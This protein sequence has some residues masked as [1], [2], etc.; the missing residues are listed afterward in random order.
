MNRL[1]CNRLTVPE[2]TAKQS[3]WFFTLAPEII[4]FVLEPT[5]KA[6]VLCPN[7]PVSPAELSMVTSVIVRP[8]APLIEKV[9]TGVLTILSP[10]IEDAPSNYEHRR[11]LAW[12]FLHCCQIHPTKGVHCRSRSGPMHR[13][14]LYLFLILRKEDRTTLRMPM[15]SRLGIWPDMNVR[16][17]QLLEF[18]C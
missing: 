5:S 12:S 7:A 15:L 6:S 17:G 14:Q 11:I 4:I 18:P 16:F 8:S 2:L 10:V 1:R 3:S 13:R 9:W